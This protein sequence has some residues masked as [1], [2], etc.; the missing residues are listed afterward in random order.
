MTD[1]DSKIAEKRKLINTLEEE[2]AELEIEKAKQNHNY[3]GRAFEM[4]GLEYMYVTEEW[5]GILYGISFQES[6]YTNSVEI[7]RNCRFNPDNIEKEISVDL[8]KE[9]LRKAIG[10]DGL[11]EILFE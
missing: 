8:F 3:I 6:E 5:S 2:I 10:C 1:L 9:K 7:Y 4:K 11:K